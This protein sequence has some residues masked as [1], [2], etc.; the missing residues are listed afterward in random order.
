MGKRFCKVLVTY[1]GNRRI[2]TNSPG[3]SI[4]VF[5]LLRKAVDNEKKSDPGLPCDVII[6]NNIDYKNKY[7]E[8]NDFLRS[9]DGSRTKTGKFIILERENVGISFGGFSYAFEKFRDYY[10][11]FFFCEDDVF[12]LK[13]GYYRNFVE[14][15][16]S[17][18]SI[19]FVA[20]A[21]ISKNP[22]YVTHASGGCGCSSTEILNLVFEK[23]GCLPH[24][25]G[26]EN[27]IR[28]HEL[29]GEVEFTG[30]LER[31]FDLEI[32]NAKGYSA[33]PVNVHEMPWYKIF[34]EK[35]GDDFGERIWRTGPK[36]DFHKKVRKFMR[37]VR[38]NT[39]SFKRAL[40]VRCRMQG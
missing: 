10:D 37:S 17:D 13:N 40:K 29:Y 20:L 19:G 31:D 11:Y 4:D 35:Y 33:F 7:D 26:E 16:Q 6:V 21:V 9:L 18:P 15:L 24:Y 28:N 3:A 2:E 39:S 5:R 8:G 36:D 14:T 34:F 12:I 27:N 22:K 23:Y 25:K 30:T 38:L 1:F 32:V